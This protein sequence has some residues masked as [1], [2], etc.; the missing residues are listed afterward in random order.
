MTITVMA[1]ESNDD[2]TWS[3]SFI[4]ITI[5]TIDVGTPIT[6]SISSWELQKYFWLR[7]FR[8]QVQA[9]SWSYFFLSYWTYITT[10]VLPYSVFMT[11]RMN[12]VSTGYVTRLW[13][14]KPQFS[15]PAIDIVAP[16]TLRRCFD[17]YIYKNKNQHLPF[18]RCPKKCYFRRGSPI[19]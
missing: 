9:Y 5:H 13:T 10:K 8:S 17:V 1:V 15:I 16:R 12:T 2:S 3:D 11:I 7:T 18:T 4:H 14:F 19:S 6:Q